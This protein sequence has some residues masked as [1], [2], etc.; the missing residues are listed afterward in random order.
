M[1]NSFTSEMTIDNSKCLNYKIANN[2]LLEMESKAR[3][4][5]NF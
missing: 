2:V 4:C 1:N 5:I 3:A